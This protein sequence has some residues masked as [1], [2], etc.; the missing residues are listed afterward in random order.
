MANFKFTWGHGV[1]LALV[2]FMTFILSL[3]FLADTP[4]DLVSE[5]YYE[6]SIRYQTETIEAEKN[7]NELVHKPEIKTQANGIN[8]IFPAEI[9]PNEGTIV[10]MRG[11]YAKD[12]VKDSLHLR[13]QQ[14]LIP[15][16]KLQKGE[17][18]MELRWTS[19]G[20]FY[21]IK[22]RIEWGY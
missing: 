20:K 9:Q 13:N 16:V 7:T 18:D 6:H 17:Y 4:G 14:Q 19:N 11:A 5:N 10:L 22:K 8:I 12:D 2:G 3:I 21:L 15:A 1:I